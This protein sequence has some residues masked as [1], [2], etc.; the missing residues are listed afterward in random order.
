MAFPWNKQ[1]RHFTGL[2]SSVKLNFHRLLHSQQRLTVIAFRIHVTSSRTHTNCCGYTAL[3]CASCRGTVVTMHYL[4]EK[5]HMEK[6]VR[7]ILHCFST[8]VA[9]ARKLCCIYYRKMSRLQARDGRHC[10][11]P[12]TAVT[13]KFLV[14]WTVLHLATRQSPMTVVTWKWFIQYPCCNGLYSALCSVFSW[15]R[16]PGNLRKK[17]KRGFFAKPHVD[18][19]RLYLVWPIT[20]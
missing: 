1:C 5:R 16:V 14:S 13:W 8:V 19:C 3:H 6:E 18:V 17:L 20:P 9:V 10:I 2:I 4:I 11:S 7:D 12:V 15:N